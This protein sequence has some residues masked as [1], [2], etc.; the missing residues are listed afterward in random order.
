MNRNHGTTMW[1]KVMVVGAVALGFSGCRAAVQTV[2]MERVDQ[3]PG[4]NRG[5]LLGQGAAAAAPRKDTREIA[6]LQVE[7]PTKRASGTRAAAVE[8]PMMMPDTSAAAAPEQAQA[9]TPQMSGGSELYAVKH[10]DTLWSIARKFYGQGSL[11]HRIYEANRDKLPEPGR[12]RAGMQ[13]HI[14]HESTELSTA[15]SGYEK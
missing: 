7:L 8:T 3:A 2:E 1:A 14:P 4:G 15:T 11:W 5:Y 9:S 12:L 6:E 13:L 10:G